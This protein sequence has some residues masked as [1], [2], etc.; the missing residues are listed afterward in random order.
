MGLARFLIGA[1]LAAFLLIGLAC[2]SNAPASETA[3]PERSADSPSA[4]VAPAT[5]EVSAPAATPAVAPTV[6][7]AE[8]A[9]PAPSPAGVT[10]PTMPD[11][12]MVAADFPVPPDRDL[13]AL[14][15]QLRWAGVEPD[16]QPARF[17][18]G[19]PEVG[20]TTN[21]WTLDYPRSRMVSKEFVLAAVS[22]HAYW[23]IERGLNVDDAD[24][25]RSVAAVEEQDLSASDRSL[26]PGARVRRG[27]AAGPHHQRADTGR[28][29][30]RVGRG[31]VSGV[32]AAVQQR[33]PGHLHQRS[34]NPPGQPGVSHRAGPRVA[35]RHPLVR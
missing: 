12:A 11:D 27:S 9:Q 4:R 18:G 17:A 32:G 16:P 5:G 30:V 3:A 25:Q 1:A 14:A 24:L 20:D 23:W 15:R 31:P 22:E 29:R 28:R 35:A 33:R 8:S 34:G 19:L 7:N 26:W 6:G 10:Q 21:F 13:P 2:D